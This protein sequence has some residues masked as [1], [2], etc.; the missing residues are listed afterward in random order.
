MREE[1]F[2]RED[3][4]WREPLYAEAVVLIVVSILFNL[5]VE[6]GFRAFFSEKDAVLVVVVLGVFMSA[7]DITIVVL[8]LPSI[9]QDLGSGLGPTIWV[10]LSYSL[11]I[12]SL[13][14]QLG[15]LGDAFGRGYIYNLGL[16]IF[17]LGSLLCGLSI[18][19]PMLIASRVVQGIGA[20]MIQANS[21][22][23][24]ADH[25]GSWERGRAFG[26]AALGW[27]VGAILGILLG[28]VIVT[29]AGWRYVFLINAPIG[30]ILA[31]LGFKILRSERGTPGCF[32]IPGASALFF[33][34]FLVSIASYRSIFE[35]FS[36]TVFL[37]TAASMLALTILVMIERGYWNSYSQRSSCPVI[38]LG[39]FGNKYLSYSLLA[40]FLQSVGMFALSF[41]LTLYLQGVRGL[42]PF[43]TSLL[44]LPGYLVSSATAPLAGRLSDNYGSR[45]P[46]SLGI[47]LMI[48]SSTLYALVLNPKM[49]L[50][51]IVI[52]MVIGSIGS[53]IFFPANNRAVM[54]SASSD[55]YGGVS[56]LLR[57]LNNIGTLLSYLIAVAV[58]S[59]TVPRDVALG[60]FLGSRVIGG[61]GAG[62]VDGLRASFAV[63]AAILLIALILSIQRGEES[64]KRESTTR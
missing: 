20:S 37:F 59:T 15:R 32:D 36:H 3:L 43:E 19:G 14:T 61:I 49:P 16:L 40:A 51:Y 38:D 8:A 50:E 46:A 62:F 42:T 10:I 17:T 56:G 35:G 28:G 33:L 27:S 55:I 26:Y 18:N 13:T 45:A 4:A 9:A 22:A 21:G 44:L 1:I 30:L 34:L 58:S 52:I 64:F 7:V 11:V 57:T 63:S 54:V 12:S 29:Y 6:V 23:V 41:I 2:Y 60:A 31:V 5:V 48:L 25:F 39:I 47:V 53:S 24:I